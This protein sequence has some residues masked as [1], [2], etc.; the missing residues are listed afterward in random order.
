MR[1]LVLLGCVLVIG[2]ATVRSAAACTCILNPPP[3]EA[4][5]RTDAVFA[6][7]VVDLRFVAGEHFPELRVTL[8]VVRVFK[9][10]VGEVV[11][12]GTARDGAACGFHFEAGQGYLVYADVREGKPL[13]VSLCSRTAR[14]QDA[15]ADLEAFGAPGLIIEEEPVLGGGGRCGGPSNVA[16]LQAMLFVLLGA[17]WTRRRSV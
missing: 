16:A 5:A 3:Q 15:A 9:G 12:V 13:G 6:G 7:Q 10:D 4:L 11:E 17:L 1:W 2:V 8:R 14:L